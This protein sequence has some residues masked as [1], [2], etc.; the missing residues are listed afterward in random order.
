MGSNAFR[1]LVAHR[2]PLPDLG[3]TRSLDC[4][5]E[6]VNDRALYERT[7]RDLRPDI[8]VTDLDPAGAGDPMDLVRRLSMIS[9]STSLIVMVQP[10]DMAL[11]GQAMELGARGFVPLPVNPRALTQ[12]LKR[13][14]DDLSMSQ[15]MNRLRTQNELPFVPIPG[16]TL[17][18]IEKMAILRSLDAAGGSTGKAAK[19]LGIS[20]RKI[21]YRLRE[22]KESQPELFQRRGNRIVVAKTTTPA[23]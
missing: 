7:L 11:V 19:M 8:M 22:W 1:V 5:I 13:E 12:I 14:L 10:S 9:P 3:V 4:V 20:V 21:Q 16:A 18:E 2:E 6:I 17:D 23:G 15:E